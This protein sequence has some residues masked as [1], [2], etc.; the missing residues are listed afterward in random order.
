M[1]TFS[2]FTED[3]IPKPY[4][5]L[6][7]RVS[8]ETYSWGDLVKVQVG[9]KFQAIFHPDGIK[10]VQSVANRKSKKEVYKDEQGKT[11]VITP[12]DNGVHVQSGSFDIHLDKASLK[13]F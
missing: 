12:M 9:S 8:K 1:K 6:P 4:S 5:K 10:K 13:K 3:A 11:W 7:V 2:Q